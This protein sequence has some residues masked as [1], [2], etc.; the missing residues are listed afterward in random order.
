MWH[1]LAIILIN[2]FSGMIY[3]FLL[4]ISD[5]RVIDSL[6]EFET[7]DDLTLI[8]IQ[9][10]SNIYEMIISGEFKPIKWN[11]IR[12]QLSTDIIERPFETMEQK[13]LAFV[14]EKVVLQYLAKSNQLKYPNVHV[15]NEGFFQ[16]PVQFIFNKNLDKKFMVSI[17]RM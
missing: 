4:R 13:N 17:N 5:Y 10:E 8:L 11:I 12:D 3:R 6:R 9:K 15:S 14:G 16:F 2:A 7:I 1:L